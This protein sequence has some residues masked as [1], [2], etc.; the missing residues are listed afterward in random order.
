MW[1]AASS[2]FRAGRA[3]KRPTPLRHSI[4][5]RAVH[6]LPQVLEGKE[7]RDPCFAVS[8]TVPFDAAREAGW[9]TA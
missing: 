2:R 6:H 3:I 5:L 1:I 7:W 9:Y 4:S 8:M